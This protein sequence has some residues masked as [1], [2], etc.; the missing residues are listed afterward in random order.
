MYRK[1][2]LSLE[3]REPR[4]TLSSA[5]NRE[6]SSSSGPAGVDPLPS[7]PLERIINE[8]N[9]DSEP[10]P[11]ALRQ[12]LDLAL[13]EPEP[14]IS[15]DSLDSLDSPSPLDFPISTGRYLSVR[16]RR[17]R[18]FQHSSDSV[19]PAEGTNVF[20]S[21]LEQHPS[22]RAEKDSEGGR[23]T[24][25]TTNTHRHPTVSMLSLPPPFSQKTRRVSAERTWTRTLVSN[26]AATGTYPDR[27]LL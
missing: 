24:E 16:P 20:A 25:M 7:S 23:G 12:G 26:S 17:P 21:P 2:S 10:T 22:P 5:Q 27:E 14:R 8:L 9:E 6:S 4:E 13:P 19:R 15:S 3:T 1:G 18:L 11:T